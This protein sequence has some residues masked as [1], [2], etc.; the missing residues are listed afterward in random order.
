MAKKRIK[1]SDRTKYIWCIA[2]INRDFIENTKDELKRYDYDVE[3]Y[4]PTVRVLKKKFKGKNLFEFIPM[5]FNYG[6]FKVKYEDACNPDFL[7]ELR[8][9]ISS[10]YGWVKDP[11]KT[12]HKPIIRSKDS[13]KAL[14]AS[15]F[16]SDKEIADLVEN[17]KDINIYSAEDINNLEIGSYIQLKGYP[18]ENMPAEILEINKNKKEIRVS[19]LL[20]A[21]VKEITV[22]FEN[23]FYSI[24]QGYD[25]S[26]SKDMNLDELNSRGNNSKD[27]LMFKTNFY[28]ETE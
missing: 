20:D 3:A 16:A 7:M 22:S 11:A 12:I 27:K 1:K 2:Y 19:L 10:I 21:L 24:Y 23:V 5:L 26:L 17:S 4:I 9:R 8:S 6:F 15:A 18:F 28:E 25:D 14:P 13:H